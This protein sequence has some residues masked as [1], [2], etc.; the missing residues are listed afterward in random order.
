MAIVHPLQYHP[1]RSITFGVVA[2][3]WA[4]TFLIGSWRFN[5]SDLYAFYYI[6]EGATSRASKN[7]TL[8]VIWTC[9]DEY[10]FTETDGAEEPTDIKVMCV[11]F[12]FSTYNLRV[13]KLVVLF[14]RGRINNNKEI[15]N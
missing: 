7:R 14:W 1:K 11:S 9:A 5:D 13:K 2:A 12:T 15:D 10:D 6:E 4:L 8:R 3:I